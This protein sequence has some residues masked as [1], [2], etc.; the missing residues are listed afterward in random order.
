MPGGGGGFRGSH[1]EALP[2]LRGRHDSGSVA[3]PTATRPVTWESRTCTSNICA[4]RRGERGKGGARARLHEPS[5]LEPPP[6]L[7]RQLVSAPSLASLNLH[8]RPPPLCV[9]IGAHG[10]IVKRARGREEGA[11]GKAVEGARGGE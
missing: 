4:H 3:E 1:S 6:Q 8:Q 10:M 2:P 5:L 11:L 7:A 9:P